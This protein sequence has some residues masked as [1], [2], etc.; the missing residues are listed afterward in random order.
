MIVII[1]QILEMLGCVIL[2][3]TLFLGVRNNILGK[4]KEYRLISTSGFAAPYKRKEEHNIYVQQPIRNEDALPRR[5]TTLSASAR[6]LL[7]EVEK[8]RDQ[9][10]NKAKLKGSINSLE[11]KVKDLF[12]DEQEMKEKTAVLN[13]DEFLNQSEEAITDVLDQTENEIKKSMKEVIQRTG[14]DK[15]AASFEKETDILESEG[16]DVLT[17]YSKEGEQTDVLEGSRTDILQETG[18]EDKTDILSPASIEEK[19]DVLIPEEEGTEV[20]KLA[21]SGKENEEA[22]QTSILPE[23]SSEET[24]ILI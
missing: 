6:D 18:K 23:E 7:E 16:T 13:S 20:L 3:I 24:D 14:I 9:E 1:G 10:R 8:E 2:S 4:I 5:R 15:T 22:E 19:T 11:E 21:F 17:D 12:I